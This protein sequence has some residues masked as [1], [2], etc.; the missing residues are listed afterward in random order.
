MEPLPI[1][2]DDENLHGIGSDI[3]RR[4]LEATA[5]PE[6]IGLIIRA[7]QLLARYNVEFVERETEN[8]IAFGAKAN[9]EKDNLLDELE[10]FYDTTL[11]VWLQQLRIKVSKETLFKEL[12][13]LCEAVED[14]WHYEDHAQVLRFLDSG[15]DTIGR[16]VHALG[17]VVGDAKY[18]FFSD[19]IHVDLECIEL[20]TA[21]HTESE[22]EEEEISIDEAEEIRLHEANQRRIKKIRNFL[23]SI[24]RVDLVFAEAI[25]NNL[26]I[27]LPFMSYIRYYQDSFIPLDNEQI[28][29]ELVGFYLISDSDEEDLL[30]TITPAFELVLDSEQRAQQVRLLIPRLL[31]S[32]QAA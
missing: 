3:V 27:G 1:E 18:R 8:I 22:V 12:V 13:P 14:L 30:N 28:A 21:A 6:H 2:Q 10:G 24:G 19:I 9:E 25:V 29:I 31:S 4:F 7:N 5:T 26:V 20:L 16:L 32:T 23:E 17:L 11:R 15:N